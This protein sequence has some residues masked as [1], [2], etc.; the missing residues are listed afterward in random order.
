[1]ER[2]LYQFK[3]QYDHTLH[4]LFIYPYI[5]QLSKRYRNQLGVYAPSN[6]EK[7]KQRGF[8]ALEE[9]YKDLNIEKQH[10]FTKEAIN[11]KHQSYHQRQSIIQAIHYCGPPVMNE[12]DIVLLDDVMTT[13]ATIQAMVQHLKHFNLNVS[14]LV[15]AIHPKL[16]E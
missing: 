4:S 3:E 16:L 5:R 11:Q 13:G 12:E 14:V 8:F 2:Y 10:L 6:H 9:I 7:T 1:M 15:I